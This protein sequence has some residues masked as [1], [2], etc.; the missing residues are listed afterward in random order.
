M[1]LF[2]LYRRALGM[3]AAERGLASVLAI[4]S[5]A[6]GLV[7]LR[8]AYPLWPGRRY[9]YRPKPRLAAVT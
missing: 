6:I 5:V 3:L 7:Q 1:D 4:A 8:R 2:R 9:A